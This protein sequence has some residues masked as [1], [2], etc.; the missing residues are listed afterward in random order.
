[1]P[2][3]SHQFYFLY[4]LCGFTDMIDGTIARKTKSVTTFGSG[5]DSVADFV[6]ICSGRIHK[7]VTGTEYPNLALELLFRHRTCKNHKS[8][9]GI[10]A[11]PAIGL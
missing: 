5:L 2:A 7:A 9:I 4:L 3:F 10:S 1:M 6:C 11:E 8:N